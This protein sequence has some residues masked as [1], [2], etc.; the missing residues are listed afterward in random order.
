MENI[1][2]Y[3]QGIFSTSIS[4]LLI[5]NNFNLSNPSK[6]I[7]NRLK[8][9]NVSNNWDVAIISNPIPFGTKIFGEK[10]K[11]EKVIK[12]MQEEFEDIV[13]RKSKTRVG[14]CL[15]GKVE[16]NEENYSI[17]NV[18]KIQGKVLGKL[19]LDLKIIVSTPYP[20]FNEEIKFWQGICIPG[21]YML[22]LQNGENKIPQELLKTKKRDFILKLIKNYLPSGWGIEFLETCIN[23]NPNQIKDDLLTIL[24]LKEKIQEINLNSLGE[25]F[26]GYE[27]YEIYFS[28]NSKLKLDDIRKKAVPTIKDH[29]YLRFFGKDWRIL[30]DFTEE[31]IENVKEEI[32]HK[33]L[34]K[35][36]FKEIFKIGKIMNVEHVLYNGK[37]INLTPGK[38]INSDS[39]NMSI[40]LIRK[41]Y[42]KGY[43]DGIEAKKEIGDYS[44]TNYKLGDMVYRTFYY[45]ND[46]RLIGIYS[47]I[48]TSIEFFPDCIRYVDLGIDVVRTINGEVKII[49][50]EILDKAYN[51]NYITEKLYKKALEIAEKEKQELSSLKLD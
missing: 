15:V 10:E 19:P 26:E 45:R 16:K 24:D 48:S 13:I 2:V 9:E 5:D 20:I 29:H 6:T 40:E 7:I 12:I 39:E 27:Y 36:I 8:L 31:L 42:G 35:N 4:K 11:V 17:I 1:S 14:S 28:Y 51:E 30:I 44:I 25:I 41:F 50:K 33:K 37:I 38:I 22:L 21:K 23:A 3:V 32:L 49:D 43:Y 47:N 46:G 18:G 34:F